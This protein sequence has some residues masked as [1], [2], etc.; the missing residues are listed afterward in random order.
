[1][2]KR[3]QGLEGK[4]EYVNEGDSLLLTAANGDLVIG[5]VKN[6]TPT[7]VILSHEYPKN[8]AWY[9]DNG[10][11]ITLGNRPYRLAKFTNCEVLSQEPSKG[12]SS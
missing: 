9:G 1:M 3:L 11:H 8:K 2:V 6:L 10:H 4:L 5:F 7:K 12:N